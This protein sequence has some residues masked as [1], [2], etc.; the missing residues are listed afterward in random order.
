M[1]KTSIA[2]IFALLSQSAL[3]SNGI[4]VKNLDILTYSGSQDVNMVDP[5]SGEQWDVS[6]DY[7]TRKGDEYKVQLRVKPKVNDTLEGRLSSDTGSSS[8][9]IGPFTIPIGLE[10]YNNFSNSPESLSSFLN[11]ILPMMPLNIWGESVDVDVQNIT[12]DEK[13]HDVVI[14]FNFKSKKKIENLPIIAG[15]SGIWIKGVPHTTFSAAVGNSISRNSL[16]C[17]NESKVC[18]VK[19]FKTDDVASQI[20]TITDE[21]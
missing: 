12:Y 7:A 10:G 3:A 19:L 13:T 5:V 1:K 21:K 14:N 2:F 9:I 15:F 6:Y 18:S 4:E 20:F 8:L 11:N 17:N 16:S